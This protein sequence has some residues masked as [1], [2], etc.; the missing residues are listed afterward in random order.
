MAVKALDRM[1]TP[2]AKLANHEQKVNGEDR[3]IEGD[4]QKMPNI[5][6]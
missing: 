1:T 4:C 3:D 5:D 6:N 2:A